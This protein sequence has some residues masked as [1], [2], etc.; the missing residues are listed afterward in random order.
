MEEIK[1]ILIEDNMGD[2]LLIQEAIDQSNYECDVTSLTDGEQGIQ[3]LDKLQKTPTM[4]QPALILLDINLPKISG[5]EILHFVKSSPDLKSIPVAI[6]SSSAY[7]KDIKEAQELEA[8]Y[9]FQKPADLTQYFQVIESIL[10]TWML[11]KNTV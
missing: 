3:Y 6:F 7:E 5:K 11:N 2:I 4:K 8:D 9:Y 1:I 10:Q